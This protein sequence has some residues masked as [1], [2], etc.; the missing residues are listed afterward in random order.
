MPTRQT[1]RDFL[2]KSATGASLLGV[3]PLVLRAAADKPAANERL[4]VACIGITGMGGSDLRSVAAAGAE[5]V[6]LCDVNEPICNEVRK[7]YPKAEFFTDFRVMLD[8]C[9]GI[10]AVTIGTPDH[11]HAVAT[12]A[13]MKAGKHVYTEK[14]LTHT[15]YEARQLAE[16]AAKLKRVTQMGTQIHGGSN[17]RRVVELIQSGA[18]GPVRECHVWCDKAYVGKP[19][20]PEPMPVPPGLHWDLWLGP[21]Q[22]RPYNKCY[23]PFHW[24]EWWDFGGGTL[25]DMACHYM[26]LPFWAL[27]LKHPTHIAAEGPPPLV[28]G[29]P[30]KLTVHYK[31]PARESMPEVALTWYHGGLRPKLFETGALPKWG[32]GV[33]FV[34][35]KGMLL[36]NY[37]TYKL[38]PEKEFEGFTPPKPFIPESIGHYKEWVEACK[39]GG[40]TTCNFD[41]SGALTE[42]VLLG[43]VA[44][45]SGK[46][47]TWDAKAFKTSE[48][49]A[50]RW[51][52]KEYRKGWTL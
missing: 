45:R 4:H 6:A 32:D 23:V 7:Q 38:L 33:L 41:Y 40:P 39:T 35:S 47:F 1:R 15:V 9:K 31:F 46:A 12:M 42:A 50:D 43:T 48:P 27:Q 8:K 28:E 52:H 26:D 21:A 37:G 51:L 5:I 34:G 19:T 24:R 22:E 36:A 18:I 17:Y 16:T 11:T 49:E 25:N 3:A 44:F 29:P 2:R 13:A 20:R 14:P 30:A 10:D